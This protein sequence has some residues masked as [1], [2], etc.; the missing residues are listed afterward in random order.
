MYRIQC[1]LVILPLL[2]KMVQ[3]MDGTLPKIDEFRESKKPFHVN[4]ERIQLCEIEKT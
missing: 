3:K 4:T 2:S 1:S